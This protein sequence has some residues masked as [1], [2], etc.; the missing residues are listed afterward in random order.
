MIAE[1]NPDDDAFC[2]KTGKR[3][4]PAVMDFFVFYLTCMGL[5][6][7]CYM[8]TRLLVRRIPSL[9]EADA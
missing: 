3:I 5:T 6:W 7:W 2:E 9:A 1:W 4:A 8:R